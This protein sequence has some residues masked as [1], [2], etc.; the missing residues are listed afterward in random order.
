[1]KR[2][3]F[4]KSTFALSAIDLASL[5]IFLDQIDVLILEIQILAQIK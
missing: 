4:I 2:R 3:D 1:M 5:P